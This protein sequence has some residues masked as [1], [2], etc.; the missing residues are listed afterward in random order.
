MWDPKRIDRSLTRKAV[1]YRGSDPGE[2]E[3]FCTRLWLG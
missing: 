1:G 3:G 2:G